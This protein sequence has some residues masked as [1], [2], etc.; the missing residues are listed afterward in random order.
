MNLLQKFC[1]WSFVVAAASPAYADI[2]LTGK[3]NLVAIAPDGDGSLLT[4]NIAF[5]NAGTSAVS[6]A[7]L[8]AK[9][10][11]IRPDSAT[12]S[13]LVGV[14]SVGDSVTMDWTV[15]SSLP[16]DQL[17]P[18]MDIP[19]NIQVE[20]ADDTGNITTFQVTSKGGVL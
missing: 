5:S 14:L 20:A 17:Y 15:H 9:D 1:L 4:F 7:K 8:V 18:G 2:M 10:P 19:F 16:S 12:D 6:Y 3:H 11:L 13:R